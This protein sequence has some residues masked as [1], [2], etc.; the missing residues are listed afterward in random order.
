MMQT[1]AL[2]CIPIEMA[3]AEVAKVGRIIPKTEGSEGCKGSV[4]KKRGDLSPKH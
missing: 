1:L 3:F 4:A 2:L